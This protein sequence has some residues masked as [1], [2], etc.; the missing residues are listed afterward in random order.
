MAR[1]IQPFATQSDGDVLYAVSTGELDKP[2]PT[3]SADLGVLA[4][5]VMWDAVLSSVPE[6]PAF[7]KPL[8]HAA[9]RPEAL[10]AVGG[11]YDFSPQV[12]VRVWSEGPRLLAQAAGAKDAYAIGR[13]A[14]VEL[15]PVSDGVF[16]VRGRYPL[17]LDFTE[18]G[19]LVINP[20]HWRQVGARR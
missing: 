19:R 17:V 8:P 3:S 7:P 14:P 11:T 15:T 6:Q 5:E 18:A 16:T 10:T 13:K 1:A 4:S 12:S 9:L 2:H 20:G